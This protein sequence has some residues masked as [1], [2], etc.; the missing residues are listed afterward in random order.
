[1][2]KLVPWRWREKEMVP[3]LEAFRG[4]LDHLFRKFSGEETGPWPE[5]LAFSPAIDIS[6]T[7]K[8]IIVKAELPGIE[9]KDVDISLSAATLTITGEKRDEREEKGERFHRVER[10]FGSFAC[11][12]SLPCRVQEDKIK[13]EYKDG[14]L[15]IKIVKAEPEEIGEELE[16][17]RRDQN[18]AQGRLFRVAESGLRRC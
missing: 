15:L 11:S 9:P 1:M 4:R 6:E 8:E 13:A 12:L 18:E 17:P 10:S 14:L 5:R 7:E 16:V 3:S 2:L